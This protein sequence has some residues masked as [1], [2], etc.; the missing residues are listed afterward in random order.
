MVDDNNDD[1]IDIIDEIGCAVDKYALNNL[2][3]PTDLMAGQEAHAYKFPDRSQLNYQC[4]ITISTKELGQE[5]NRP[6]CSEPQGFNV[7]QSGAAP[8]PVEAPIAPDRRIFTQRLLRKRFVDNT[9][10]VRAELNML[11]IDEQ[12]LLL[13]NLINYFGYISLQTVQIRFLL[14]MQKNIFFLN[15]KIINFS[16]IR[17]AKLSAK[18]GRKTTKVLYYSIC[19]HKYL[20]NFIKKLFIFFN[21]F[22]YHIVICFFAIFMLLSRK[23]LLNFF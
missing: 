15:S 13:L 22:S 19:S 21:T 3:Y 12:V 14:F 4:Q 5:C 2:E 16:G 17:F 23:N 1:K 18:A 9:L 11:D 10:D 6:M 20:F 7:V 8:A